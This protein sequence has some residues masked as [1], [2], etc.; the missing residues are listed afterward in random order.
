MCIS[1]FP[2]KLKFILCVL[3]KKTYDVTCEAAKHQASKQ[4]VEK[5]RPIY[6]N[7]IIPCEYFPAK[8]K[9]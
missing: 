2:R 3:K 7:L 6:T 8:Q 9:E 5:K 1:H 4:V